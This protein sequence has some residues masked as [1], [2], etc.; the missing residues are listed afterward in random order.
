MTEMAKRTRDSKIDSLVE[1]SEK[2]GAT[3]AKVISARDI[4]VDPRVR[5]KC[6]VPICSAYGTSLM[7]PPN[8]LTIGEFREVLRRYR[9]AILVQVEAPV[10]SSDKSSQPLTGELCDS[11]EAADGASKWKNQLLEL[12]GQIETEAFKRGYYLAAGLS[13]GE[14]SLCKKCVLSEGRRDCLHPFEARP[15]MEAVGIDVIR[16]CDRAGMPVR[17][18]SKSK[19]R[20]TGL[21]LVD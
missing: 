3:R 15:S 21:V 7:C 5:L 10:D 8:V 1:F 11:I 19:I 20:W 17:L 2:H 16:T 12:V 14:C 9:R 6:M 13:G 4:V 18:S